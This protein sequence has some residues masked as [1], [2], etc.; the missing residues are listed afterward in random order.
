MNDA[1]EICTK[2]LKATSTEE[3][4]TELESR[5]LGVFPLGIQFTSFPEQSKN[6]QVLDSN[7]D[8]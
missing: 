6:P 4:I 7:K 5:G 3:L 1:D 8:S 2:L